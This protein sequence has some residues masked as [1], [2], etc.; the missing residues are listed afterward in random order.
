[1]EDRSSGTRPIDLR[2]QAVHSR[3]TSIAA[4]PPRRPSVVTL[5][6]PCCLLPRRAAAVRVSTT[7]TAGQADES[8]AREITAVGW[9]SDERLKSGGVTGATT[10]TQTPTLTQKLA[11]RSWHQ[12]RFGRLVTGYASAGGEW[13]TLLTQP[14]GAAGSLPPLVNMGAERALRKRVVHQPPQHQ[15]QSRLSRAPHQCKG[16]DG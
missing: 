12:R 16:A 11:E 7:E 1:M 6:P 14:T 10:T 2:R 3:R 13:L 8:P 5:L 4:P 15:H 9:G